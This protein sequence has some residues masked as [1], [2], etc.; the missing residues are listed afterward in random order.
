MR[1]GWKILEK[2]RLAEWM[3]SKNFDR[4]FF[5]QERMKFSINILHG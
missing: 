4:N 2:T 1:D 3:A 5:V